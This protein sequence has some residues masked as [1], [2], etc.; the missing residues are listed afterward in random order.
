MTDKKKTLE[1]T[2]EQL[3]REAESTRERPVF[4]PKVDIVEK[5]DAIMLYAD[6]PGIDDTHIDIVLEKGVLTISGTVEPEYFKD[7]RVTYAEYNIGDFR[8]SFAIS[9]TI[10]HDNIEATV[11][12]G[13]L[14]LVLPK[15]EPAKPKKIRVKT[16]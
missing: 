11:K 13:V 4:I 16:A 12:N 15:A 6:M 7:Y 2:G 8:R 10:D 9:D 5:S 14:S 1:V 3:P